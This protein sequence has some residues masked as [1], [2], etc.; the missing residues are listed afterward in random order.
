MR[1]NL[2]GQM[3]PTSPYVAAVKQFVPAI[4][5]VN[6]DLLLHFPTADGQ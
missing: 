4:N 3:N 2:Y 1:L 6:I 5:N